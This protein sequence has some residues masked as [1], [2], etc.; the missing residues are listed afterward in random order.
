MTARRLYPDQPEGLR[1]FGRPHGGGFESAY[2]EAA[3]S[4]PGGMRSAALEPVPFD[5]P[6]R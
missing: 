4:P 2:A 5:G 3:A 1:W 6:P